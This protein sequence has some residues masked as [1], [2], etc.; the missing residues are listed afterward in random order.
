MLTA[1][2]R[3]RTASS[4]KLGP[5][6]MRDAAG[7]AAP[8]SSTSGISSPVEASMPL[9]QITTGLS[10]GRRARQLAHRLRRA[11]QQQRVAGAKL[12]R[13]GRRLDAGIER[14]CPADRPGWRARVAIAC[15][16]AGSRDH[17]VTRAA[18]AARQAGERRAPGAAADDA[19][20]A[21]SSAITG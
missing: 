2:G 9:A 7:R 8:R 14:R 6:S 17:K 10:P 12:S 15:E 16:I 20:M 1:V 5:D 11:D 4:A 13:L 19:D 21:R 3:P 18:G